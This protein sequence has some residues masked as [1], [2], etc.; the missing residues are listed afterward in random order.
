MQRNLVLVVHGI[1]EQQAG[2]TIDALTGGALRE[3]GLPGPVESRVEM[4]AEQRPGS[5]Q[6]KL[7]PCN[8]RRSVLPASQHNGFA[9]DQ[10][11]LAGE[12]YWSDLSPAPRGALATGFDLLRTVL[13]LGYLALDNVSQ[14]GAPANRW[15]RALVHVFV[16]IF[17]A[18]IAPMNA[19]LLIGSFLTLIDSF[20]IRVG[21]GGL[22]GTMLIALIGA[23]VLAAY[24]LWRGWIRRPDASYLERC[25]MSGLGGLGAATLMAGMVMRLAQPAPGTAAPGWLGWL[26]RASCDSVD[27]TACW[28]LAYQDIAALLW[29]FV[30]VMALTWLAAVAVLLLLFAI[31]SVSEIGVLR[32]G[33]LVGAPLLVILAIQVAPSRA[34]LL[35]LLGLLVVAGALFA[36]RIARRG[37]R[38]LGRLT[39]L[40]GR[41][42]RIYLPICNA[43]LFLWMLISA[44]LWS[45]FS[46]LVRK[47]DGAEG[48]QS[49]LT[50]LYVDYS[51][52]ATST[53]SYIVFGLAGLILAGIV[54]LAIRQR[55]KAALAL[56]PAS[57]LDVWCGRV[58]LNPVLNL[59]L[60]FLIL[61]IAFGGA[62]QALRTGFDLLGIPYYPWNTDTLIGQLSSFHDRINSYNA[63]AIAL[64]GLVGVLAY[65]AAD[66]ISA[67]LGVARD[68]SVYSAR[69]LAYSPEN[70][71]G[72][73]TYAARQ[74]I[75]ARFHMVHDYLARQYPHDRLIVIAHSQGTVIAAQALQ[76]AEPAGLPTYLVTM[77]SPLTHIY[78][79]YFA[80]GFD[81]G[82]LPP[83]LERWINIYRCDDFVGT[84]VRLPDGFVENYRIPPGGHT[85]YWTD[86]HVWQAVR[87]VLRPATP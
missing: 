27:F 58:I 67:A 65:R 51:A 52:L 19:L 7:F 82:N 13:T 63:L 46:E 26:R 36:R 72:S 86:S 37:L 25:F 53:M 5:R 35:L 9:E 50:Q 81:I 38:A 40:F 84:E 57:P 56:D 8:I 80:R 79:Q 64:V 17:Y 83:R 59:L 87:E 41:R 28:N 11:V 22:H 54:P 34:W 44:A 78:G 73:S 68:I 49:L 3:L 69:T 21:P 70:D 32:T 42:E 75:K 60:M 71:A 45:L 18:L 74:R 6:L 85:G 77:G 23:A 43:M 47:I 62:L 76:E 14:S 61:W 12:I 39:R 29:G 15:I 24:L 16:W 20:V 30:L 4:I 31:S 48:G 55:R 66:F 2:Q 33:L 1:G 10:E